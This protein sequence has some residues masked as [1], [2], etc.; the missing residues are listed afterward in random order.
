[1]LQRLVD[2]LGERSLDVGYVFVFGVLVLCGFG[3]PMPEDVVLVT[4]GVLAWME[5][6]L[7]TITIADMVRDPGLQQMVLVGLAG[8][9]AGDSVIY[10]LGRRLGVRVSAACRA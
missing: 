7:E 2:L 4:G 9:L 8:I 10:W 5:S 3:F 1:M 6:P